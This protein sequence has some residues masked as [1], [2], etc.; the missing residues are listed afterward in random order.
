MTILQAFNMLHGAWAK[1]T[2]ETI[3]NFLGKGGFSD[4]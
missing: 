1:V 4:E 2:K 3:Q